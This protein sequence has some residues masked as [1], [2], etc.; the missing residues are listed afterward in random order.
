MI[1]SNVYRSSL[2]HHEN[3]AGEERRSRC[4]SAICLEYIATATVV[5]SVPLSYDHQKIEKKNIMEDRIEECTVQ[6]SRKEKNSRRI[7]SSGLQE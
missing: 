7:A 6:T 1:I 2:L 4:L 5:Q 3:I